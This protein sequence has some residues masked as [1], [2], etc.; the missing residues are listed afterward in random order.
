MNRKTI[1]LLTLTIIITILLV[2]CY[3]KSNSSYEDGAN[4]RE[5]DLEETENDLNSRDKLEEKIGQMSIEEK[6]GQILVVGFDEPTLDINTQKL[7]EEHHV[8]GVILFKRNIESPSQ[9]L[10]LIN[11]LKE[12]NINNKFPLFL[13]L[14]EEGGLVSRMPDELV[15]TP[16]S[17]VIGQEKDEEFA[18]NTGKVIGQKINAF[19]FNMNFAPVLDIDSNPQNPVIGDRA[20][21]DN[22]EIVTKMG[23]G[24]MKGLE[25]QGVIAVVKHF[26]GHGDTVE[27][28]HFGLPEIDKGLDDLL[29]FELFPFKR[30]IDEGVEGVMVAHILYKEIDRKNPAT[31]SKSI[32][33]DLLREKLAFDGLVITD[34]MTM[35][36]ILENY[37]LGEAAIRSVE[38]GS[39]LILVCHGFDNIK[40]TLHAL[41]EAVNNGR[42]PIERIDESVYRILRVKED[43]GLK[44]DIIDSVDV[45]GINNRAKTLINS[46]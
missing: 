33:G 2:A 23:I 30:A 36:A 43:Y 7:I 31:L 13:S 20:Y 24:I 16:R 17:K 42:I 25:S 11:S 12:A 29:D 9:L 38:A 37:D 6:I 46:Q 22:K 45:S 27:D 4:Y 8:G 19:G 34:D 28:S 3:G 18:Y 40:A 14:D 10:G 41:K 5:K 21:G 26:P 32:I 39:D 1:S 35:G 15:N 44:D